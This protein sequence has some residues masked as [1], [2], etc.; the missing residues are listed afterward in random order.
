MRR[1][2]KVFATLLMAPLI[3]CVAFAQVPNLP[4]VPANAPRSWPQP[5]QQMPQQ[6]PQQ[7]YQQ[8]QMPQ[9]A[10]PQQ[11]MPQQQVVPA[12][13]PGGPIGTSE[14]TTV[15][16]A[17]DKN[18]FATL[19]TSMGKIKVELYA[20]ITPRTVRNFVEL[21]NGQKNFVDVKTGR[22]ERRAFYDGLIFHKVVK[23]FAIQTGCPY[24]TGKGGPG[25]TF[26]DEI[27]PSLRHD[28]AGVV[29]MANVGPNTNGSQFFITLAPRPE[30]DDKFTIFGQVVDGMDVLRKIGNVKVGPTD[31]PLK[32]V[33]LKRI[34]ITE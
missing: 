34:V 3:S 10:M 31:R 20:T 14:V 24:G 27:T 17:G 9:Q 13:T 22:E 7:Q 11:S 8:Q 2:L 18:L 25:W 1:T 29:S 15:I 23:G 6:V 5:Q 21:A 33:H 26:P 4:T 30:L 16:A 28:K 12:G 32:R 19:E